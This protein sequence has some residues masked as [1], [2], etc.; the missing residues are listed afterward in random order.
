MSGGVLVVI[1]ILVFGAA[2]PTLV[3]QYYNFDPFLS[4]HITMRCGA[5]MLRAAEGMEEE[6]ISPW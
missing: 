4:I 3:F 1:V 5:R 6:S 2:H